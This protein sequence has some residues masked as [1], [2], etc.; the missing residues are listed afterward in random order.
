MPFAG[1]A[2]AEL[3]S[4]FRR[5]EERGKSYCGTCLVEQLTQRGARKVSVVAWTAAVEEAFVHPGSLQV[6]S[7]RCAICQTPGLSIGAKL[8]SAVGDR[9]S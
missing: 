3:D 2:R 1:V 4:F 6:R 8:D 5:Q 9:G 7:G